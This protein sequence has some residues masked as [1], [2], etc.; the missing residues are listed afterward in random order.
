MA[1]KKI[2]P[3]ESGKG[4]LMAEKFPK[5][6][7]VVPTYNNRAVLRRA[8]HAMAEQQYPNDYEIIVVNDGSSDGTA[9][10]LRRDFGETRKIRIINF[11]KNRGV[12][13]ARNAGIRIARY[14]IL[15]NMDHDCVP[16]K[17]WLR[18]LVA[19]F[20]DP[21]V[22]VISSFGDYG[23]TS[24]AFRKE[25]LEKV[26]GYDERYCYYREDTDVTFS[27]MELGYKYKR[28]Q[29]LGYFHD[30]S[31]IAPKGFLG[32]LGY[33][34]KRLNYHQNDALLFKKHRK[35]ASEFFD[36]KLGFIVNPKK[37]FRAV[38]GTWI[39]PGNWVLSSP[40]GMRLVENKTAFHKA[41]IVAGGVC[42]A[43]VI[44]FF[45]LLGSVKFGTLLL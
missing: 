5:A 33:I 37:D 1:R 35:L 36:V 2:A 19:G 22:G 3:G 9:E 30:H 11:E 7:I 40:R 24:T 16:E 42:Y 23:G 28:L 10:M 34:F 15:V 29:E 39:K 4:G 38:A 45:R 18:Y 25:L 20:K 27:I 14:P 26:G 21:N 6:S 32:M 41:M 44:K 12:C 43:I 13:K 8:L 31:E 17:G